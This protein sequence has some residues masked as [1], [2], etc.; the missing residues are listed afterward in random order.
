MSSAQYH[1]RLHLLKTKELKVQTSMRV[2]QVIFRCIHIS[3]RL[4][5]AMTVIS[6]VSNTSPRIPHFGILF[7]VRRGI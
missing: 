6:H 1:L 5:A 2:I 3:L 7:R 4:I